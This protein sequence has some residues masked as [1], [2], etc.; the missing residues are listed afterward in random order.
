MRRISCFFVLI[1]ILSILSTACATGTFSRIVKSSDDEL[2]E[3]LPAEV[4]DFLAKQQIR[5]IRRCSFVDGEMLFGESTDSQGEFNERVS[6]QFSINWDNFDRMNN[7]INLFGRYENVKMWNSQYRGNVNKFVAYFPHNAGSYDTYVDMDVFASYDNCSALSVSDH[8]DVHGVRYYGIMI[9]DS[10]L[11]I[12]Q[13]LVDMYVGNIDDIGMSITRIGEHGFQ[14]ELK[15]QSRR[16]IE[17]E[18]D[19]KSFAE[20]QQ[21]I[22]GIM[23]GASKTVRLG[24]QGNVYAFVPPSLPWRM[25]N[26]VEMHIEAQL[27]EKRHPE[28]WDDWRKFNEDDL[29]EADELMK[30][31]AVQAI[32]LLNDASK[33]IHI[34]D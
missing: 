6:T 33:A 11:A 18:E 30:G 2:I 3:M 27:I 28:I 19:N 22:I 23:V 29:A 1:V 9:D 20:L 32:M 21:R 25:R 15:S 7:G 4:K 26:L 12:A 24:E 14:V 34:L 5:P 10:A 16:Y 8:G 31:L 13:L 17:S